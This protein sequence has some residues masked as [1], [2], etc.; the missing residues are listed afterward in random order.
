MGTAFVAGRNLVPSPAA[1][2]IAV[3]KGVDELLIAEQTI[4][5]RGGEFVTP[6]LQGPTKQDWRTR[7]VAAR[8][9]V[10]AELRHR[11]AQALAT[12]A[13]LLAWPAATVC[14]YVPV[15]HE[16]GSLAL[17]D[18]LRQAGR[19]VLLPIVTD[20]PLL[21]W[22]VY[23]GAGSLVPGRHGLREPSGLRLGPATV[24]KVDAALV[25]A[26][27]VD[28]RGVRLG[29]GAGHYDRALAHVGGVPLIAV[30]R[31]QELVDELPEE[32]HDVRMTAVLTPGAGLVEL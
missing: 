13:G 20:S 23:F 29:R 21:D 27:A 32:P 14:A 5:H 12:C 17:L 30:V 2:T 8:K 6:S 22:G 16:P 9:S 31:D 18:E 28:R 15:G 7:V 4:R 24:T 1:G 10:S 19:R 11:E 25:P 3:E 26:L